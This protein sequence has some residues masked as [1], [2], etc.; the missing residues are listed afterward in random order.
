[1]LSK[2]GLRFVLPFSFAIICAI[3]VYA[4]MYKSYFVAL[5]WHF[6]HGNH[7]VVEGHR[8]TLPLFWWGE[9]YC[10]GGTGLV[11]AAPRSPFISGHNLAWLEDGG[12][13]GSHL[14]PKNR[15]IWSDEE[16]N[17]T[18]HDA[19][20]HPIFNE[21][22]YA[23]TVR[24]ITLTSHRGK[25]YCF[26]EQTHD[27]FQSFLTLDCRMAGDPIVFTYSGNPNFEKSAEEILSTM[28]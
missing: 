7:F 1:M 2:R 17:R 19:M 28:E 10:C 4:A 27:Y 25:L 11:R 26:T 23:E 21:Q 15:K 13:I 3:G 5:G 16:A 22:K 24:S 6:R 9:S 14:D 18:T 8:V 20:T 12:S